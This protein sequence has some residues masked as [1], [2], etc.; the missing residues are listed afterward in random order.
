VLDFK[1]TI[2]LCIKTPAELESLAGVLVV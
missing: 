1:K 2:V